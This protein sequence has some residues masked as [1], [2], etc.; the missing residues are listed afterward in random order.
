MKLDLH[1][2]REDLKKNPMPGENA[3][4]VGIRA[5]DLDEN[6]AKV[7]PS[8]EDEGTTKAAYSIEPTK[9]GWKLKG[10]KVFDVCENGQPVRYRFVAVKEV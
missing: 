5:R 8:T 7:S 3:P 9:E 2:F 1:L 4:P 10:A 6:F